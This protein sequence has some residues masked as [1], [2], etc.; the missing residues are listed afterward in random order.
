MGLFG[1]HQIYSRRGVECLKIVYFEALGE[2]ID[3]ILSEQ[4]HVFLL[5]IILELPLRYKISLF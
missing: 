5:L 1:Q 4:T 2:I 3:F